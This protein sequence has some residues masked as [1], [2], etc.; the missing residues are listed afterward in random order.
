MWLSIVF[1]YEYGLS[2]LAR[3]VD[4]TCIIVDTIGDLLSKVREGVQGILITDRWCDYVDI[5]SN[6]MVLALSGTPKPS[7]VTQEQFRV[8]DTNNF[9]AV[10]R[11]ILPPS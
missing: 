6:V 9:L 3:T 1:A 8:F 5:P 7:W 2:E 11:Q 4:S 10:I